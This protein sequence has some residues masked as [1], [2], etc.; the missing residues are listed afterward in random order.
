MSSDSAAW[1]TILID[2]S[3]RA[4]FRESAVAY[5]G[6]LRRNYESVTLAQP[7]DQ[8]KGPVGRL[9]EAAGDA[10]QI[11]TTFRTETKVDGVAG[12]PDLGIEAA[13]LPVGNIELKAPGAGS[14]PTRFKDARSR[15]QWVRFKAL[16]NLIYTD[17]T[18][19]TLFRSG[20]QIGQSVAL[21]VSLTDGSTHLPGDDVL[22]NLLG[23]LGSFLNWQPVVPSSPRSLAQMLAPVTRLLRDEVLAN[24]REGG[25]LKKLMTEWQQTLFPDADDATFADGY[26]Q[27]FTYA[28]LLARL[29]G[30][31]ESL[32]A[33]VAASQLD[34]DHAL[35]AQ[36]LR[37]I[38][39][40]AVRSAISMPVGLLERLIGAVDAKR[41][42]RDNDPWLYFY[43]DFLAAYDPVQRNNRGVYYTPIELV[44]HIVASTD[45]ALRNLLSKPE[46]FGS[47]DVVTLDPAAGTGTFPLAALDLAVDEAQKWGGAGYAAEVAS[48]IARNLYAFELLVGPYAVTHLRLARAI[49][50][51][52]GSVP[53][54]GVGVYLTDTL[55]EAAQAS[56]AR[57]VPIFEQRLVEE[58]IRA[59]MVKSPEMRV[60]VII[61]NPPYDRDTSGFSATGRRKGGIV[62]HGITA[63]SSGLIGD[64]LSRL[65]MQSR[66][67]HALQLYNDYVYFWRWAI[68]KAVEQQEDKPAVVA[69]VTASSYLTGEGFGG[70]RALMRE[71]FS[72]IWVTDLGGDGRGAGVDENVFE[73][74]RTPVAIAVCIRR[75]DTD[76]RTPAK[77]RYRRLTGAREEKLSFLDGNI[78]LDDSGYWKASSEGATSSFVPSSASEY[79]SWLALK[80]VFPWTARGIQF[81]R[82]WPVAETRELA[83]RRWKTLVA[84]AGSDRASLLKASRDADPN[85]EYSSFL[86]VGK[87]L[88]RISLLSDDAEADGFHEI[89]FRSFDRQWTVADSRVIDMPRPAL[90][91]VRSGTQV[92]FTSVDAQT[93]EGPALVP[94]LDVPDLNSTNNR[95]GIVLPLEKGGQ[96]TNIHP[97]LV[98]RLR[99][100][101]GRAVEPGHVAAYVYAMTGTGAFVR[102]FASDI[103]DDGIRVPF[104]SDEETFFKVATA[105]NRL[106]LA[107]TRNARRFFWSE[108]VTVPKSSARVDV[109]IQGNTDPYP[110]NFSYDATSRVLRVGAG[111]LSEVDPAVWDFRVSGYPVLSGWLGYR[112]QVRSGKRSSDLDDLRPAVWNMTKEL[113]DLIATI[114]HLIAVEPTHESLIDLVLGGALV[115]SSTISPVPPEAAQAPRG[116]DQ[117]I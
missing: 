54:E 32:T 25:V 87:R 93:S 46:G 80:D 70:L 9:V 117:L 100:A 48:R 97:G 16:P 47:A 74:I 11:E 64:L 22:D 56:L 107:L 111:T 86:Q 79:A 66:A 59:G 101:F 33:D 78:Q 96:G 2:E 51:A 34:G 61:G 6:E 35:L 39:Q 49:S 45:W 110:E 55:S 4:T 88:P 57:Q 104:T 29:E 105:G 112:M 20:E 14:N 10:T 28:L 73:G 65:D 83:E 62:R 18:S 12:R 63:G 77:V 41:L 13:R 94:H 109:P 90:W 108:D 15:E 68:W 30:A 23:L 81:S 92:Y 99:E 36:S 102:K 19:W 42:A 89:G 8:L 113:L 84:S 38:G 116:D 58:Q 43:E 115:D 7:E 114:S 52:G 71:K 24:V 85:R 5:L 21:G 98:A 72:D 40:P 91:Q 53:P 67:Q 26:A 69:F 60:T 3:L 17:G 106:L 95:G 44:R 75:A 37:V 82:S 76:D 27:T 31:P 50:D 103:P 1:P